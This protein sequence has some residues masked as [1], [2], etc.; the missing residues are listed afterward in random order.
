MGEVGPTRRRVAGL[1]LAAGSASR[2]GATKQLAEVDGRPLVAHVVDAALT[3][4]LSPVVVVVGHDADDVAAAVPP[5]AEVVVNDQYV[6]GQSVSL[7]GGI[8]R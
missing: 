7:R 6:H 8:D 5:D 4:E 1:V 3:A 2:F